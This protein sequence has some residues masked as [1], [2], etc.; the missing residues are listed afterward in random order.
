MAIII[1]DY[2]NWFVEI[3]AEPKWDIDIERYISEDLRYR[4]SD[5][6]W[7]ST[8][9][10][11]LSIDWGKI[12]LSISELFKS[13]HRK[14]KLFKYLNT[15]YKYYKKNYKSNCETS[16]ILEYWDNEYILWKKDAYKDILDFFNK[17]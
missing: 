11:F 8:D 6:E 4:L 10:F 1:L 13:L 7:I 9:K 2:C 17:L 16:K 5:L 15:N 3:L 12:E 14:N